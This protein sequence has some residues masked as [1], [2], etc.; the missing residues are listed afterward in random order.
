MTPFLFVFKNDVLCITNKSSFLRT[1]EGA[2]K[3]SVWLQELSLLCKFVENC[4]KVK[5]VVIYFWLCSLILYRSD[6]NGM[7][8]CTSLAGPAGDN[9][10]CL[11]LIY[12]YNYHLYVVNCNDL[13]I[14]S[15]KTTNFK[16]FN[17]SAKA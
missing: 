3:I 9:V 8:L 14:C 1:V 6:A 16:S 12:L 7:T 11:E 15:L 17:D 4:C 5:K 13:V 2:H 10:C